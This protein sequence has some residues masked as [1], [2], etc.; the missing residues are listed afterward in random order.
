MTG[1]AGG[2]GRY[3]S[4]ALAGEGAHV[5]VGDCDRQAGVETVSAIE[6]SGGSATLVPVD[7]GDD[8]EVARLVGDATARGSLGVLVN[9]A[10]GWGSADVQYPDAAVE[11]WSEVLALNLRVPMLATQLCL[12]A[13]AAGGGGAVVNVSSSGGLGAEPYGSPPYAAAKAGLIRFTSAVAATAA[14]R[15]VR[16]NCVVPHWIGLDRAIGEFARLSPEERFRSGPL[17]EP[18]VVTAEVIRLLVAEDLSGEII[19]IRG[20][21]PPYALD[22]A[23]LDSPPP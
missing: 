19:A 18:G 13:M 1:G 22:P 4:G 16:V 15:G 9:N 5:V 2:L 7:V 14:A 8:H 17:I 11:A 23:R 6:Q 10:G 3:L 20:D 21:R 12:D